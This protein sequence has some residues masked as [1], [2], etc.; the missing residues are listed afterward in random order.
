VKRD[1][2]I[3]ADV[4][5]RVRRIDP[6]ALESDLDAQGWSMLRE[7]LSSAQCDDIAA[8]YAQDQ[9]FRS[10]VV[11]ARRGFGKGEYRYFSYPLPPLVQQLRTALYPRLAPLANRW[12]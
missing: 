2:W 5:A 6:S 8:L 12:E 11:M 9:G 3:E 10:R 7:L 1:D 4:G